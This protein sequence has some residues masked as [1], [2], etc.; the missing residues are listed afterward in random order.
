MDKTSKELFIAR[1]R[2]HLNGLAVS[3]EGQYVDKSEL[4]VPFVI[5]QSTPEL[6]RL[7]AGL[8]EGSIFEANKY[9]EIRNGSIGPHT[10]KFDKIYTG[11]FLPFTVLTRNTITYSGISRDSGREYQGEWVLHDLRAPVASP[12]K[13]RF[14]LLKV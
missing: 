12:I 8:L 5:A 9:A 2:A 7:A 1:A 3:F 4:V 13:G 10:I 14:E 6:N 11:S